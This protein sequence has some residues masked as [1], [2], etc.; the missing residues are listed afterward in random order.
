MQLKKPS[1]KKCEQINPFKYTI[2]MNRS[3]F[4]L[5]AFLLITFLS[6]QS[7]IKKG[8][9]CKVLFKNITYDVI[10]DLQS[11]N[12]GITREPREGWWYNYI[13]VSTRKTFLNM[14]FNS[15]DS[16]KIIVYDKDGNAIDN[17]DIRKKMYVIDTIALVRNKEPHD[18]YDTCIKK[19]F[20]PEMINMIRF[21]E[22]WCYDT[23]TMKIEKKIISYGV[24]YSTLDNYGLLKHPE[25][26][27]WVRSDTNTSR[28][29]QEKALTER[30][31]YTVIG[32]KNL[33]EQSHT[34]SIDGDSMVFQSYIKEFWNKAS[35]NKFKNIYEASDSM[36]LSQK[37]I[38]DSLNNYAF[39]SIRKLL[40]LKGYINDSEIKVNLLK[41]IQR[42][43]VSFR[44][45]EKWTIDLSTMELH[46]EVYGI[47][48]GFMF[49]R[50]GQY[51]GSRFIF[52]VYFKNKI[53]QPLQ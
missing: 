22:T 15:I 36:K 44:F 24:I 17:K 6:L 51:I 27:F 25:P 21:N 37:L 47:T 10:I 9:N 52:T 42:Y 8:N 23:I 3:A 50:Y 48:A 12:I 39:A 43:A 35:T 20:T 1:M 53:W 26:I 38:T 30:I 28:S 41:Y 29:N 2:R 5:I 18:L 7:C 14:L 40:K 13:D 11:N 45:I 46:K 19:Y 33:S 32:L 31:E 34:I 49:K 4:F 16:N